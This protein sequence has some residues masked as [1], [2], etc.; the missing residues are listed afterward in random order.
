VQALCNEKF[1]LNQ[2]F[3]VNCTVPAR[4]TLGASVKR[5][6]PDRKLRAEKQKK[7]TIL[8]GDQ[9]HTDHITNGQRV[10]RHSLP[11]LLYFLFFPPHIF[12]IQFAIAQMA[13]WLLPQ[14]HKPTHRQN[15]KSHFLPTY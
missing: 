11:K 8:T 4:G 14:P 1:W 7:Q 5:Q 12:L 6:R 9:R 10:S 15:P 2:K 13:H 3:D